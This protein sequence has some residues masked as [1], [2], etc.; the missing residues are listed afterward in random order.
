[1]KNTLITLS[2]TMALLFPA[3]LS[4]QAPAD[5]IIGF[6]LTYDD[7]TGKEKSQVRIYKAA[8]GK[9]EGEIVWL[10]EPKE[11][12]GSEK[13]DKNNPEARLQ[14]RKIL[15]L[16]ILKDFKYDASAGEWSGGTIYNPS[17]GKTYNSYIKLD[18]KKANVR[19]YIGKSW[20]G[21]GKTAVWTKEET[22]R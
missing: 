6:Y 9:Y 1:M 11:T 14:K 5:R 10:K 15:G 4:A 16:V 22:R 17:S 3:A 18:G 2:L 19:G 12:D 8:N 20:M 7:D 21:L 13:L